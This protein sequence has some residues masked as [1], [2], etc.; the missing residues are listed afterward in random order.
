M[1]LPL[2]H[3][4]HNSKAESSHLKFCS[5]SVENVSLKLIEIKYGMGIR[6]PE[7]PKKGKIAKM[8]RTHLHDFM[9]NTNA[10][11][12]SYVQAHLR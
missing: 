12:F 1:S 7:L 11:Q 5:V 6:I 9:K 3:V 10:S 8:Q 4:T 2:V